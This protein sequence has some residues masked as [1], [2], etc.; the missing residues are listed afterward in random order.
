MTGVLLSGAVTEAIGL[1][2]IFGAFLFGTVVPRPDVAGARTDIAV[3]IGQ[4][5]AL[6]LPVYF[7]MAGQQVD[8]TAL[9]LTDLALLGVILA[10]SVLGKVGGTYL[11]ARTQGLAARPALTLVVLMNTRG[12]TELVILGVGLQLELLDNALYSL[13][14]VMAL[15][16]TAMTGP[17]LSLLHRLRR[18]TPEADVPV[19]RS[20]QPVGAAPLGEDAQIPRTGRA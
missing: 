3:P 11:G 5:T 7:V 20:G 14:V 19:P 16:T 2:Y 10:V 18:R 12:L 17:L 15:V 8:L 6:L 4:I 1:H 9:D 13:M